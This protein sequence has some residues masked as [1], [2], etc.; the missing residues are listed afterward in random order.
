M[1]L[2]QQQLDYI[3]IFL[4]KK[5]I[6]YIDF[7]IEIFDHI[8]TEIETLL[9]NES[10]DFYT[11]FENTI[12]KW[13]TPLQETHSWLFGF[14]FKAPR[15]VI[16]KAT[17]L[18]FPTSI[19]LFS[20]FFFVFYTIYSQYEFTFIYLLLEKPIKTI[21]LLGS[22][23]W[24]FVTYKILA[25]TKKTVY[26]FII[27]TQAIGIVIIP[28]IVSLKNPTINLFIAITLLILIISTISNAWFYRK[29]LIEKEKYQFLLK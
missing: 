21:F 3:N 18:F 22:F 16:K 25:D 13:E 20:L 19:V 15:L 24:L 26:S 14:L 29:H 2:T 1:E 8:V 10:I 12:S 6:D 23:S 9:H 4:D 17:K 11:A 27:K 28:T 5:G 7:R